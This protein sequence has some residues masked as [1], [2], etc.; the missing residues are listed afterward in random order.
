MRTFSTPGA[1]PYAT[2]D[3]LKNMTKED[4]AKF[5][6]ATFDEVVQLTIIREK[7]YQESALLAATSG[8]VI[9]KKMTSLESQIF[10]PGDDAVLA[11]YPIPPEAIS[12]TER[13]EPVTYNLKNVDLDLAEVRYF[14]S[15]DARL[16]GASG[17]LEEDSAR[18]AS[19]H[20]AEQRDKHVL[21]ELITAAASDN[22]V[23]ATATW[24]SGSAT[25][26][27]DVA[28]AIANI[29]KNS[30]ISTAQLNKP[31]TFALIIP[32]Q[33]FVGVTKL[34]LI[35]NITQPIRDFLETEYKVQIVLSRKPR[36]ES[37]WPVS[38][39]ALVVPIQDRS[40]GF[41]GTFDGGGIVPA[42]ERIRISRGEDIITRQWFKWT[43]IPEP[44][45]GVV[46]TNARIA[47]ITGVAT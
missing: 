24:T 18:R 14:I 2:L 6:E 27:D 46:T 25:P 23:A 39:D 29:I 12:F 38:T 15:D 30:N 8:V 35:R 1:V 42:Q 22:T 4:I 20:L 36:V 41:L 26:E 21:S 3:E 7:I 45:N 17:W 13:S 10:A 11:T 44:L 9:E 40:I 16:R 28:K 47:K 5:S 34:K 33:A 43:T 31:Q 32:A 37:S 19:E